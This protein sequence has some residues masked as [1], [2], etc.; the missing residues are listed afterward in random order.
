LYRLADR[1]HGGRQAIGS[2]FG[3]GQYAGLGQRQGEDIAH[4]FTGALQGHKVLLVEGHYQRFD[5]R[6][7]LGGGVDTCGEGSHVYGPAGAL[8]ADQLVLC[9][10]GAQYGQI[11]DL[12]AVYDNVLQPCAVADGTVR[13][14]GVLDENVRLCALCIRVLPLCPLWPPLGRWPGMRSDF[15]AGLARPSL[16][17]GLLEFLL[18]SWGRR[19]SS[20][21]RFCI[22]WSWLL[23]LCTS[24]YRSTISASFCAWLSWLKSGNTRIAWILGYDSLGPE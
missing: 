6:A 16:E 14:A 13:G 19:S 24:W 20:V 10:L 17:G 21:M 1:R 11:E 9:N 5:P 22:A 3:E 15:R 4:E 8:R 12:A 23:R 18:F 7:V 2:L